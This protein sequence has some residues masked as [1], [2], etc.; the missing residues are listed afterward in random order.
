MVL[1][2]LSDG[3]ERQLGLGLGAAE[4]LPKPFSPVELSSRVRYALLE[5]SRARAAARANPIRLGS[6]ELV[7]TSR[8]LC[9]EGR[10]TYLP[11]SEA[12]LLKAFLEAPDEALTR[13]QLTLKTCGREWYPGDRTIDVLVARLRRR[14]PESVALIVTIHGTGYLLTLQ[15]PGKT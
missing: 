7:P 1:S 14:L 15:K 5:G 2:E 10:T 6:V 8:R 12:R 11:P 9:I 4:Y 13:D 3:R